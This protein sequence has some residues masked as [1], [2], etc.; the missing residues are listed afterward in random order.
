MTLEQKREA[1]EWIEAMF[2]FIDQDPR[3]EEEEGDVD[4]LIDKA[5]DAV[6]RYGVDWFLLDPWN[7]VEHKR[8]RH[9]NEADYQG[10]AIRA[11]KRFARSYDCGV[12]RRRPP[13]QGCE[14]AERRVSVVPTLYDISGSAH[15]Y[16]AAD[17]GVIVSGDTTT[18]V[19]E[20][21]I[22][23]VPL[24]RGRN[25]RFRL[26]EARKWAS[27]A[28]CRAPLMSSSISSTST[29]PSRPPTRLAGVSVMVGIAAAEIVVAAQLAARA[30]VVVIIVAIAAI[31]PPAMGVIVVVIMVGRAKV[32]ASPG[33]PDRD[34]GGC[35]A[36]A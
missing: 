21:L 28:N 18:N 20:I 14:A 16:N 2:C 3:E 23:K 9:E 6:V 31:L 22:E 10:R 7:Q 24:P 13:D 27:D 33:N 1:D 17:H 32:K 11:L 5:S 29:A 25:S 19:R 26:V 34:L 12:D 8:E 4:W 30:V 36:I 15:W 35:G